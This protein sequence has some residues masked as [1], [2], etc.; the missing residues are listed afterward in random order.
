M[1]G[2][3]KR[4]L[5]ASAAVALVLS[6]LA[7]CASS[8]NTAGSPSPAVTVPGFPPGVVPS[9]EIPTE[10]ANTVELRAQVVVDKCG[11]TPSGW[12][13]SGVVTNPTD[14]PESL[15]LTVF[16]TDEKA[17]VIDFA[18]ATV[19]VD[20]KGKANWTAAK[21]VVVTPKMTWGLRGVL[22]KWPR[23]GL[24]E[25]SSTASVLDISSLVVVQ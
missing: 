20:A 7:G 1:G 8:T 24:Q 9:T 25:N 10:V 21:S 2:I 22:K 14:D 3:L 13:A 23:L 5:V 6:A 11:K 12:S 17:T 19:Q 16:F 15:L 4:A 18:E